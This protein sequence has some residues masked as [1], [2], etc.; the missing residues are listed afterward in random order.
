MLSTEFQKQAAAA[1]GTSIGVAVLTIGLVM[2]FEGKR[3]KAY[4]DP[5]G[6]PTICYGHTATAKIGQ[7]L[8][9][10]QCQALLVGDLKPVFKTIH[11][12]VK[13]PLSEPTEAALGSFV[14]HIGTTRFKSSTLLKKLNAS[15]YRGA[16]AELSLWVYARDRK[17]GKWVILKGIVE[18]R[19][20]ERAVCE[21]GLL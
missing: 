5:V 10:E 20:K 2:G 9:N 13:V 8:T 17:T 7:T 16:F 4:Y 14:F 6:I 15:D 3:N 18:R 12:L 19:A 21:A 1:L 11:Q